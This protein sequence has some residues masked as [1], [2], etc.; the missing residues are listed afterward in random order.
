MC[1]TRCAFSHSAAQSA[2]VSGSLTVSSILS[3]SLHHSVADETAVEKRALNGF[4]P[5]SSVS[6]SQLLSKSLTQVSSTQYELTNSVITVLS[7]GKIA[8]WF[9]NNVVKTARQTEAC[10]EVNIF[11]LEVSMSYKCCRMFRD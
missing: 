8:G 5:P 4:A 3:H 10:S 9:V 1:R 2:S 11:V 6:S 7:L